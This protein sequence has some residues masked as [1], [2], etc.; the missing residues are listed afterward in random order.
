MA[1]QTP[2]MDIGEGK[3]NVTAEKKETENKGTVF[4]AEDSNQKPTK[5]AENV[6]SDFEII[7]KEVTKEVNEQTTKKSDLSNLIIDSTNITSVAKNT[8][9]KMDIKESE[10]AKTKDDDKISETKERKTS[11]V[12]IAVIKEAGDGDV[13]K[14]DLKETLSSMPGMTKS[15]S[16][17]I[18]KATDATDLKQMA[19]DLAESEKGE[20]EGGSVIDISVVDT[21]P[22]TGAVDGVEAEIIGDDEEVTISPGEGEEVLEV[23]LEMRHAIPL[24]SAMVALVAAIY[25]LIFYTNV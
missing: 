15:V 22:D 12:N 23:T 18:L 1:E 24:V 7:S 5:Q 25:A 16:K 3:E 20:E 17:E 11:F 2:K 14:N 21:E 9:N 19:N 13:K 6:E 4:A 8:D 10:N